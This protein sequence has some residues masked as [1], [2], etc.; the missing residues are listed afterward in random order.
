V[1]G[2]V[3]SANQVL[4][5][6]IDRLGL[7]SA[8]FH[9]RGEQEA[10]RDVLAATRSWSLRQLDRI[11]ID[12]P[13]FVILSSDSGAFAIKIRNGL[14]HEVTV[15]IVASAGADVTIEAPA[16]IVLG[17]GATRTVTLNAH[18]D[19]IGVH[20]VS[21]QVAD[22]TGRAFS[23]SASV[24]LRSNTVGRIIWV[25]LGAGVGILFLAIGI[26]WARRLRNRTGATG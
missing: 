8:S 6:N 17:P 3:L 10:V 23:D 5:T 14:N 13:S 1:L 9:A 21:L 22:T 20:P 4:H 16:Q 25:I 12:T 11:T 7:L 18:A 15:T 26:R 24:N 19:S 2:R